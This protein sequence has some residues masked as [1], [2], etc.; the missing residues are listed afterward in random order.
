MPFHPDIV[1]TAPDS[2]RVLIAVE[3][4]TNENQ[5]RRLANDIRD[6][7]LRMSCPVGL[8]VFPKTIWLY[9]NTYT[10]P[11]RTTI[12][13]LG[14]YHLR[15]ATWDSAGINYDEQP[16]YFEAQV[17]SWLEEISDKQ[18]V[19]GAPPEMQ[20]A[21]EAYVLPNLSF[22]VIRAAGPRSASRA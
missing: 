5:F 11:D 2:A 3:A 21:F 8:M 9:L 16:H 7:L 15:R 1:V 17:Q 12:Q 4:K 18:S 22:G 6:Y 19:P 14:P 20:T 13:E 10:G